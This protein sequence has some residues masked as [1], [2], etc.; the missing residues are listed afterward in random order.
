MFEWLLN[1][2]YHLFVL[3]NSHWS[4]SFFDFI[5]PLLRNKYTW[6]PLYVFLFSFLIINFKRKGWLI[7]IFL[8]LTVACAD[9]ISSHVLKP[10]VKRIRPCN[11]EIL[12]GKVRML[13]GCSNS[14]SFPSSHASNHFAAAIFLIVLFAKRRMWFISLLV[15]WA[16]AISYSQVYVGL[17]FPIDILAGAIIGCLMGWAGGNFFLKYSEQLPF[18]NSEKQ[19]Q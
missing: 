19:Q 4:N 5:C 12:A 7:L 10:A 1:L 11:Q 13:V 14:Y 17:H 9:Q 3:I 6:L 2:D 8:I 18:I 16:G 15:L